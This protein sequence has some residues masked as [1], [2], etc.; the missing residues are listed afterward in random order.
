MFLL[1]YIEIRVVEDGIKGNFC[2][3]FTLDRDLCDMGQREL[4]V[5]L[6]R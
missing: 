5:F 4:S 3:P 1:H 2:V 6:L